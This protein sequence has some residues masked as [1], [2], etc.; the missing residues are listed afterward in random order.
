[1]LVPLTSSLYVPGETTTLSTVLVDVGTGY[2][3]EKSLPEA[4]AFLDRKI[5]LLKSQ[6]GAVQQTM[7]IKNQHLQQTMGAMREKVYE[8]RQQKG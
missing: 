2:F 8:S 4:Q 6:M 5:E 7:M 3:I 1:M